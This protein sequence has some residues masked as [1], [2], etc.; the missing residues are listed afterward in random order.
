MLLRN[1]KTCCYDYAGA[2]ESHS[3]SQASDRS[4]NTPIQPSP[5][6]IGSSHDTFSLDAT[7][8]LE[9][10]RIIEA[11]CNS[12][13]NFS[14]RYFSGLHLW[15]PFYCPDRFGKDLVQFDATPTCQFSVLLLCMCLVTYIPP[16]HSTPLITHEALYFHTKTL[17]TQIRVLRKPS[18]HLVQAGIFLSIYEYAHGQADTA[19][20]SI[21]LCVR[22]AYKI[23][24]DK[25]PTHLGWNENWNTWW[26]L[27]IFERIFYCES[28]LNHIPLITTA[29]EE[30]DIL[31][32]EVGNCD[33][34]AELNPGFRVTP[35]SRAGVGCLGRAA[36]AVYLLDRVIQTIKA[37]NLSTSD[38]IANLIYLD[39]EL[40]R[41]LTV[42]MNKCHSE[43][44][45]Q[46]GAVGASIR[47]DYFLPSSIFLL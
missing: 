42:T 12:I 46:C 30:T 36:Q 37:K 3:P 41:L 11:T 44:G 26:S 43:R 18:V 47:F 6:A 10:M 29:P 7:I 15:V 22:L 5:V 16:E 40:Q 25:K 31:P 45:G 21:D 13:E 1:D 32:H 4:V 38:Q 19:L 8:P 20:E 34:V 33:P 17:F 35:I 39:G 9:V 23:G 27:C 2:S 24:M 28:S 14:K